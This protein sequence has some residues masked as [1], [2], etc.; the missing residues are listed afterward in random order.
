MEHHRPKIDVDG[1]YS[2]RPQYVAFRLTDYL[3][4]LPREH[5]NSLPRNLLAALYVTTSLLVVLITRILPNVRPQAPH[6]SA[7]HLLPTRIQRPFFN[8][9]RGSDVC[10]QYIRLRLR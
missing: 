3:F 1:Y 10:A 2:T 5:S 6:D 4:L 9:I 7:H 8:G